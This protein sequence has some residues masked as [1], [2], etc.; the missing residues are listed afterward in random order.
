MTDPRKELSVDAAGW[1]WLI[2]FVMWAVGTV[3]MWFS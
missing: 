3:A 2:L 1:C